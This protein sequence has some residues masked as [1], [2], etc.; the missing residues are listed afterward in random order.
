MTGARRSFSTIDAT[1]LTRKP[2]FKTASLHFRPATTFIISACNLE[3]DDVMSEQLFENLPTLRA[4]T[5]S[6]ATVLRTVSVSRLA[7]P[8]DN[9]V[10]RRQALSQ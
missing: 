10:T 8:P 5:L 7:W 4:T 1:G 6:V 9:N 3:T 2:S